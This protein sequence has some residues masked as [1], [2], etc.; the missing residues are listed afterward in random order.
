MARHSDREVSLLTGLERFDL[1]CRCR[2]A[3]KPLLIWC[4]GIFSLSL[5]AF[6]CVGWR[7]GIKHVLKNYNRNTDF[8]V[9]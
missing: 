4:L 3:L 9:L 2:C 5:S 7:Q 1:G 8:M 6:L